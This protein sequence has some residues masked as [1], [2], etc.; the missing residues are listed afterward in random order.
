LAEWLKFGW[1]LDTLLDAAG[2]L[3]FN[4][5]DPAKTQ[6]RLGG[7]LAETI[8][9]THE[10]YCVGANVQYSN[11]AQY[12]DFLAN[13]SRF[14]KAYKLGRNTL[15]CRE[16]HEH[17][18]RHQPEVH[19]PHIGPTGG[20]YYVDDKTYADVVT[21]MYFREPYIPAKEGGMS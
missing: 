16:V 18:L 21:E 11:K 19:C 12:V 1:L 10:D 7:P 2:R 8:C 20:D 5:T 9:Q 6:T 13:K 17:M 15:L 4:T 14:G 3:N